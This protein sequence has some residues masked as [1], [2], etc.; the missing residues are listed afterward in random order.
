MALLPMAIYAGIGAL[1]ITAEPADYFACGRRVSAVFS[2]LLLAAA[3]CG[4]VGILCLTGAFFVA[5]FDAICIAIGCVA[6]LVVM[7]LLIAPYLRKHGAYTVP[8]FLGDRLRNRFMRILAAGLL[9]VPV[10]LVI[11]AELRA[12]SF[13]LALLTGQSMAMATAL[14][15]LVL[16][17]T[18]VPGGMRSL[19]WSGVAQAIFVLLALAVPVGIIGVGETNLPLPQLSHG[20]VLRSLGRNEVLSGV[21]VVVPAPLAFDLPGTDWAVVAKRFA[22]PFGAVGALAFAL[23]SFVVMAG[24]AGAPW[25][26][27]RLTT[28]PSVYEARKSLGWATFFLGFLM[29]TIASAAV[30]LR[31]ALMDI[32]AA[33]PAAAMPAWVLQL[34][35][36]GLAQVPQRA[37]RLAVSSFAFQRDGVLLGIPMIGHLPDAF[38]YLLLA[39]GVAAALVAAATASMAL[40]GILGED[41]INGIS[42]EPLP[43]GLRIL[44]ARIAVAAVVVAAA[45]VAAITAAD[46]LKLLLWALGL[47]AATAFPALVLSIWWKRLSVFGTTLGIGAGFGVTVL[48][49]IAAEAGWLGVNSA[50][51]GAFGLPVAFAVA[52]CVS[53]LVPSAD[54]HALEITRDIRIPGG[55]TIYDKEQ[56]LQRLKQRQRL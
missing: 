16:L 25:L 48:A 21:P 53:I 32:I 52:I 46:P 1:S 6:G 56:R 14:L 26:L 10:L 34:A 44:V 22:T 30:F 39:G 54:R 11:V 33:G 23:M 35:D 9:C 17:A 40:A 43:T 3:T 19:T 51:A 42:W 45:A 50:L 5:G 41:V 27:P 37:E 8:G 20:P 38:Q 13:A 29:V 7:A 49:I 31:D 47:S 12:G 36:M 24:V 2:G 4:A 55:E 18:V 28:T 15:T